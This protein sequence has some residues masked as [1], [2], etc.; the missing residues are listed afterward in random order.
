MPTKSGIAGM[1]CAALGYSRGS[2]AE[3]EFLAKFAHVRMTAVAIPRRCAEKVLLVQRL[4]DYHTVQNTKTADGKTKDCHITHR[5]YLTDAS[6]CVLLE[7][8]KPLLGKIT[9]AL[10]NPVWGIWLGRKTCIPSAPV[11]A[12]LKDNKDDALRLVIG[13]DPVESF[14]RQEEVAD[15]T[16]GRDSLPDTPV[17]FATKKRFFS[18]RRVRTLHGTGGSDAR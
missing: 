13:N 5:Q 7:G 14:T 15:F 6:F 2:V 9:E 3:N 1:C 16:E 12:G 11:I 10:G 17:S 8:P 4:Q 18:P